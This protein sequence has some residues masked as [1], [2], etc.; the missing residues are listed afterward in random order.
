VNLLDLL[1]LLGLTAAIIAGIRTGALPQVFG[2][3]G[4][5]AGV[6]VILSLA[7]WL[8]DVTHGLEPVPRALAVLAA[9]LGSVLLFEAVGSTLGR[10]LAGGL[11]HGMLS[12][13]DRV[14]GGFMGAAQAILIIWLAGGLLAAGPFPSLARTANQSVVVR[15]VDEF[16]PPPTVV[17][18]EIAGALDASGLPDVFVGLDP[19]PLPAVATPSTREARQIADAAL[20]STARIVTR[21]CTE[22]VTGTGI[23]LAPDY[24]VTNAH[25]IAGAS[26]I[27]VALG[28]RL[29]DGIPVL[30]D[31]RLDVAL[32]HT[33]GLG[34]PGVHLATRVPDR[35]MTGAALG[36]T[37]GGPLVVLPAGVAGSYQATGR[38]IYGMD[39]VT[40][41]I[42]ELRAPI[43]PGD[44]G[45]PL[46]LADGT[47]GGMVFAESRS[48]PNVGYALSPVSVGERVQ[49]AIG[50]T[51]PVSVGPCLR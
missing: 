43:D 27:R 34:G 50:R 13:A 15:S 6:L 49:P 10:S 47:V 46:V 17:V 51:A 40:R 23:L 20:A 35:G 31:A 24:M 45:G 44:S 39:Q 19:V 7:P 28:D 26:S 37:G 30:F 4:A 32:L 1:A 36:F 33:P 3:A 2:I 9:V 42:L 21:A 11:Q 18:G 41:E 25:V 8:L 29:V 38:D 22:Q 48:D 14:V 16:L 12:G 5:V